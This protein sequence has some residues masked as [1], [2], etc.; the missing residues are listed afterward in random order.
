MSFLIKSVAPMGEGSW[1]PPGVMSIGWVDWSIITPASQKKV[2][3]VPNITKS[4][5][6]GT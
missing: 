6:Y 1:L 4:D 3:L 2:I 5:A